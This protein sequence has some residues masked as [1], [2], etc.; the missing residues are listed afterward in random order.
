MGPSFPHS[1]LRTREKSLGTPCCSDPRNVVG[2]RGA[3][4][5]G[6]STPNPVSEDERNA[7]F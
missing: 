5:K 6:L 7:W 1:L 2:F 3:K 4:A